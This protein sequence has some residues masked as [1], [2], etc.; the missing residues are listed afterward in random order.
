MAEQMYLYQLHPILAFH[1]QM[2]FSFRKRC[3]KQVFYVIFYENFE[4]NFELSDF[5]D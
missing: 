4:L 5:N 2:A 1:K 3:L